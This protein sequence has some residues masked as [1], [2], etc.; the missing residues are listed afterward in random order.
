MSNLLAVKK[1]RQ[2]E[3]FPLSKSWCYKQVHLQKRPGLFV[4]I[5]G[6]LFVDLDAFA[7]LTEAGRLD[8]N[9]GAK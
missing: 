1:I 2:G 6:G 9:G 7:K 5:G 3:N 4:K 8:A